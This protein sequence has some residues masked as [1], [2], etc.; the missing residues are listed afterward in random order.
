M[1]MPQQLFD[2]GIEYKDGT[3]ATQSQ[4]AKDVSTFMHWAAEPYHDTRKIY[5]MK[6]ILKFNFLTDS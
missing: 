3:P 5:G 6:V 1:S 4:Q 2:E